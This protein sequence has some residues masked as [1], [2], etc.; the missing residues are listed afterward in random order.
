MKATCG[1]VPACDCSGLARQSA[2]LLG[3][4]RFLDGPFKN[5]TAVLGCWV[6]SWQGH[7]EFDADARRPGSA[8]G[9]LELLLASLSCSGRWS[10]FK[11]QHAPLRDLAVLYYKRVRRAQRGFEAVTDFV[12]GKLAIRKPDAATIN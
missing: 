3:Q 5:I 10:H 4:V 2:K 8:N 1:S 6:N 7:F 9:G 12:R 11:A